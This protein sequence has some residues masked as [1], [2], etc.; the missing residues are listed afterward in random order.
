MDQT[1]L[2]EENIHAWSQHQARVLR[3]LAEAGIR[4]PNDFDPEHA[5]EEI[6]DVGNEQRFAAESNLLHRRSSP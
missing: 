1:A 6:E 4:L 5:A 3:G 2:Y